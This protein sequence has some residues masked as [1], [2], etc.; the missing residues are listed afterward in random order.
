MMI[1][2]LTSVALAMAGDAVRSPYSGEEG[3]A[4]KALSDAD[5]KAYLEGAGM[6]LARP[7]ELNQYP[8]PRHVLENAEALKLNDAQRTGIEAS[9]QEM[10]AA[11]LALGRQIVEAERR[12]DAH[13]AERTASTASVSRL[14]RQIAELQGELRAVHLRA[15]VAVRAQL[16]PEQIQQYVTLRG[17][18]HGGHA[19]H[20]DH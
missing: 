7:A 15:H 13:F 3:R 11:A 12:L 4:I 8:G 10:K 17:Y 5:V 18:D 2:A 19:A 1:A 6:G 9:F 20:D 16:T 14:T